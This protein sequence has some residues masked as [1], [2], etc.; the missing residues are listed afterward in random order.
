MGQLWERRRPEELERIHVL[1]RAVAALMSGE[2][3]EV[4]RRRAEDEAHRLA[5]ALG[6][7]GYPAGSSSA[8]ELE[9]RF[10]RGP[11]PREAAE[12]SRLVGSVRAVV[13]SAGH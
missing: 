10:V 3:D 11:T 7:L 2:L 5:G 12:L 4:E 9:R 6:A 1:E 13:E 8:R